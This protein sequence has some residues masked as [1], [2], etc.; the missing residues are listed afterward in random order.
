MYLKNWRTNNTVEIIRGIPTFVFNRDYVKR[1]IVTP[2][3]IYNI[4]KVYT[5]TYKLSKKHKVVGVVID[6]VFNICYDIRL[7]NGQTA[8]GYFVSN[9]N[10]SYR[11]QQVEGFNKF[12]Y[13]PFENKYAL[14]KEIEVKETEI[15]EA[16]YQFKDLFY[17][18]FK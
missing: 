11:V 9:T 16:L 1:G 12:T 5:A 2:N 17:S 6:K 7:T 13:N 8:F 4:N 18:E 14:G 15:K 3:D 10:G